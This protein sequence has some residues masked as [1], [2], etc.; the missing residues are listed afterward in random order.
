MENFNASSWFAVRAAL[1]IESFEIEGATFE[2]MALTDSLI[3]GIEA[4]DTHKDML[5]F[6]ADAGLS[7][8]RTRVS[9]DEELAK[10]IKKMW[11]IDDLKCVKLRVG[12]RVCE[13]SGL[14][15]FLVE[16]LEKEAAKTKAREEAALVDAL[17]EHGHIDGDSELP[18]ISIDE[19]NN[20]AATHND[21][22]NSIN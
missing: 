18:D 13:I 11:K 12:E 6:A 21:T 20:D 16:Q 15:D 14:E 1:N 22:V 10:D 7:Y 8:D 2:L 19:L 17:R 3:E 5:D 4:C 9:D